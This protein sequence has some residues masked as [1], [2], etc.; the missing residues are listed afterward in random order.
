[1]NQ[2]EF[3]V[4]STDN[5][6]SG[7]DTIKVQGGRFAYE[8]PCESEGTL[9]IVLP[10][11]S[12]L[13]VFVEPGQSVTMDA[14][15]SHI[16]DIK[17]EGTDANEAMTKWRKSID[18]MSPQEQC[19]QA[20]RFINDNPSSIV[21]RWLLRK[22][23]ILNTTPDLPKARKLL[24]TMLK[25]DEKNLALT[26][27]SQD[28]TKCGKMDKGSTMPSFSA[29]DINGKNVSSADYKSG[30]TVVIVVSTWN[31]DGMNLCRMIR[32]S[33]DKFK[34][35][36]KP[37]PHVLC[38]SMDPSQFNVKQMYSH[39]DFGWPIVCDG[40]MWDSPLV[41]TLGINNIPDNLLIRNGKIIGHGMRNEDFVREVE[42]GL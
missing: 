19:K 7:V 8:I 3:Y 38:I 12:E 14:D 26:R 29:V 24:G 18:N 13:P 23:F 35:A 17:I 40:K 42:K 10:N 2:G 28:L 4:Y 33:C 5:A 1:M 20:E 6:I 27:L 25:T 9:V 15:A 36:N 32:T 39:E 11:F 21:S 31:Y 37:Q 16:K 30:T 41:K 34:N 22:Y